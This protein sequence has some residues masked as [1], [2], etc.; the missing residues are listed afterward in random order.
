MLV[1]AVQPSEPAIHISPRFGTAFPRR[2]PP[3]T[4]WSLLCC[5]PASRSPL[6]RAQQCVGVSPGSQFA[7]PCVFPS[8]SIFVPCACVSFW[9]PPLRPFPFV[10]SSER[11][12]EWCHVV[13]QVTPPS[14]TGGSSW[15]FC[16]WV[17]RLAVSA[18][19]ILR[20]GL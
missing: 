12:G 7:P 6:F 18:S 20:L 5:T 10:F 19:G 4:E 9:Q 17:F 13:Y 2:S 11:K 1:S 15:D 3:S 16:H 14:F 8:V